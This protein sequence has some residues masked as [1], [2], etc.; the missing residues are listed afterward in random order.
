MD[1]LKRIRIK[2]A[3]YALLITSLI[4]ALILFKLLQ[5]EDCIF[6]KNFIS[7]D[8]Y[9]YMDA[10]NM[11]FKD[12]TAHSIRPLGFALLLGLPN[13]VL[14]SVPID[15]YIMFGI[16]VN[17]ILWL[18]IIFLLYESLLLFIGKKSSFIATIVFIFC[19][20][21]IFQIFRISTETITT[22]LLVLMSYFLFKYA[23]NK[24]IKHLI[25]VLVF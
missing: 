12:L 25:W 18:G 1:F 19:I 23:K 10:S 6:N 21:N 4:F 8:A 22:F 17:L 20:G 3:H 13:L 9:T 15:T 16:I 24:N 2:K 14:N 7:F 5:M 11:L